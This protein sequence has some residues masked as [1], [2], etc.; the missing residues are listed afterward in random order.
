MERIERSKAML[1]RALDL[2]TTVAFVGSG[3][4]RVLGYPSWTEFAE[5]VVARTV[6]ALGDRP[7]SL[8]RFEIDRLN[9]FRELLKASRDL[10][11]EQLMSFVIICQAALEKSRNNSIYMN[12]SVKLS[13]RILGRRIRQTIRTTR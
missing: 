6:A 9:R 4:S 11:A 7:K 13:A 10:P 12:I 8:E 1:A 5:Q 2:D 3:L